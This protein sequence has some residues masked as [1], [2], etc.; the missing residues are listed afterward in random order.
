MAVA[1][2]ARTHPVLLPW[3]WGFDE[4]EGAGH[5]P[6]TA[7]LRN[8]QFRQHRHTK[9][10]EMAKKLNFPN[11]PC[12]KCGKPIHIKTKRH[13]EC[14]WI[15]NGR[16]VIPQKSDVNKSAAVKEI[17]AKN[18]KTKVSEVVSTLAARGIKVSDTYVYALKS[19][20]KAKKRKEKREKAV[21]TSNSLGVLDPVDL[22]RE[23]KNLALRT[24]GLRNLKQL[25]EVLA[26]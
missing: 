23:V 8:L 11:R 14:G 21:A 25:V 18:P 1:I 19:K 13:E 16:A 17:L 26:E 15:M 22:I 10:N 20:G 24:G 6:W 4:S 7:D 12:P 2:S 9:E 3:R 5:F